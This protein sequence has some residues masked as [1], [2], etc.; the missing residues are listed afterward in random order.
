MSCLFHVSPVLTPSHNIRPVASLPS[1]GARTVPILRLDRGARGQQ[2][3]DHLQVAPLSRICQRPPASVRRARLQMATGRAK[4]HE[5][6]QRIL[7]DLGLKIGS[8]VYDLKILIETCIPAYQNYT[9]VD[10]K[11]QVD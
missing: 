2:P 11:Q 1:P 5:L 4:S 10:P 7:E 9:T 8:L 3:L 6:L